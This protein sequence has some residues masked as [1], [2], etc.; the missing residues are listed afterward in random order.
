MNSN[1]YMVSIY[2]VH[3]KNSM[4]KKYNQQEQLTIG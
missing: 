3:N 1:K 4:D 2:L